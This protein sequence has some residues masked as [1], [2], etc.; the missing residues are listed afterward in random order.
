MHLDGKHLNALV[1]SCLY[2]SQWLV[3]TAW[4]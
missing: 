2:L 4:S 3:A 1:H